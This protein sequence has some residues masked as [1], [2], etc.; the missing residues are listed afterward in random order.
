M[1]LV[2]HSSRGKAFQRVLRTKNT[3]PHS[4]LLSSFGP[5][6]WTFLQTTYFIP[7]WKNDPNI[8]HQKPPTIPIMMSAN[9]NC[10]FGE[11]IHDFCVVSFIHRYADYQVFNVE[12]LVQKL[13][14]QKPAFL[15]YEKHLP[16]NDLLKPVACLIK[17]TPRK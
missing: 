11:E 5:V 16:K 7:V 12:D 8:K 14:N 3:K 13:H 10:C 17:N 6:V 9:G 15:L 2:L 4:C 1:S